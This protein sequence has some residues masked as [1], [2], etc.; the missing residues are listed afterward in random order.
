[1]EEKARVY[2][3]LLREWVYSHSPELTDRIQEKED[4]PVS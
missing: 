3:M 2:N 1:M 4:S